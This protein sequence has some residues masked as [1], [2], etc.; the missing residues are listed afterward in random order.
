MNR[1][2]NRWIPKKYRQIVY[3]VAAFLLFDL[4]V[5]VLN[6]YTSYQISADAVSINLAGRQRMLSQRMTKSLLALESDALRG[7]SQDA[8]LKELA[9]TVDLFDKT[10][11]GFQMGGT[12]KGGDSKPVTLKAL[13]TVDGKNILTKAEQ[14]WTPYL[15][16]IN[17]VLQGS[18]ATGST[19]S[20][21]ITY[22]R[23]TNIKLLVLMNDLTTHLERAASAKANQLRQIQTAGIAL[24]L[25]NFAFILFHFIRQLKESDQVIEAAQQETQE[26]L[27]TVREGLFLLG[28]DFHIGNQVSTSLT[29]IIGPR[30]E[31]GANLIHVLHNMLSEETMNAARDY[32]ELLFGDRVRENLIADLNPLSLVEIRRTNIAGETENR[33]LNLQ[34]NQVH[35]EGRVSHLLVTVQDV[36]EQVLLERQLAAADARTRSEVEALLRLLMVDNVTLNQFLNATEESL[37]EI[38]I[39]LKN[40]STRGRNYQTLINGVFRRIHAIKGDAA[41]L[42]L[43]MFEALAHEFE[44]LLIGLR[45]RPEI[46]GNDLVAIPIKLDEFLDRVGMVRDISARLSASAELQN[47]P[48]GD[49]LVSRFSQL[50]KRIADDLGK[51]VQVDADL[52]PLDQLPPPVQ[53]TLNDITLQLLRNAVAH[54][55]ELK[56]ERVSRNKPAFGKV[57]IS[58]HALEGGDYELKVRDDGK[59]LSPGRI[60][61][62]LINSGRYTPEQVSQ[63]DDRQIILKIFEPGFSTA[64]KVG[65]DA[66]HGV[67]M[68]VVK[69]K[70]P[71]SELH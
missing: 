27:S 53:T 6:F 7:K 50:A 3:A 33:Y 57:Q 68:D 56:E 48:L 43:D 46:T 23:N 41:A 59:G 38:N 51:A 69:E 64:D 8:S 52:S 63:W 44:E 32:I 67:G 1:N 37:Y 14:I 36:T 22:A 34:F 45:D 40:E 5:L 61:E 24:A 49:A 47:E 71:T 4:G 39:Q 12:V 28:P 30:A 62:A 58:L 15:N 55:I 65:R 21:A 54:G 60:R 17:P 66:G 35:I 9:G 18:G 26:I 31:P 11:K 20:T 29:H 70:F 42:R 10:L 16:A 13:T 19:L 25:L 2:S